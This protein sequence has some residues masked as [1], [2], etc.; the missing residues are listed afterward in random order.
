MVM[1]RQQDHSQIFNPLKSCGNATTTERCAFAS[2]KIAEYL[3]V[4][5]AHEKINILTEEIW[6]CL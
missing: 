6:I 5:R 1:G 4:D 3:T 2:Q